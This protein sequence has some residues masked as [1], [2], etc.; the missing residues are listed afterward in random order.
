MGHRVVKVGVRVFEGHYAQFIIERVG[1]KVEFAFTAGSEVEQDA[2]GYPD[3]AGSSSGGTTDTY[4][5][6]GFGREACVG[7]N[8]EQ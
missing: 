6:V 2:D 1:Y 8:E 5:G 7:G 3:V 4:S